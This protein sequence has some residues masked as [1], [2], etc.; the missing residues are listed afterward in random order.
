MKETKPYWYH[1][2]VYSMES[3]FVC[4][5]FPNLVKTHALRGD[6]FIVTAVCALRRDGFRVTA[7]SKLH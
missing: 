2:T 7:N 6:G 3:Y 4:L 5:D 1:N